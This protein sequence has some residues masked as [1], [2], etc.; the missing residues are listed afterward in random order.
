[1]LNTCAQLFAEDLKSKDL[2]FETGVDQ[3]GDSVIKFPYKG[4]T[5]SMFFTGD[6]G[7]YFSIYMAYEPVPE[8]KITDVILACNELN[9]QYKWVTF[10]VDHNNYVVLHDDAILSI[11]SAV[12]EAFEL[13]VRTMNIGEQAKPT[14]MKAIYA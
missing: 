11:E 5:A 2:A 9:N 10:Y 7:K 3:D 8:D 4:K 13:L 1:M 12:D 6:D 14:I